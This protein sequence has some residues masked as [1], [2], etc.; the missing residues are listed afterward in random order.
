MPNRY[1]CPQMMDLLVDYLDGEL[2]PKAR[3]QLEHHLELCPPCVSFL[4]TYKETGKVCRKALETQMPAALKQN[5]KSFLAHAC[6]C[7]HDADS[8]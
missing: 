1:D 8:E 2:D 6:K 7:D 4:E 5:L 3:D